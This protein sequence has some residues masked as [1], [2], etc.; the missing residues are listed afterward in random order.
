MIIS[1][2]GDWKRGTSVRDLFLA[3][4]SGQRR[5]FDSRSRRPPASGFF[6]TEK[7]RSLNLRDPFEIEG[8]ISSKHL[9]K[10]VLIII[11]RR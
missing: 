7:S 9:N 10:D 1:V 4:R 2:G 5:G 11:C 8:V 6:D 3:M